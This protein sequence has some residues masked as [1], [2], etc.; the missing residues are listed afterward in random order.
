MKQLP[1]HTWCCSGYEFP[2]TL[3]CAHTCTH[4]EWQTFAMIIKI[5]MKWNELYSWGYNSVIKK[6]AMQAGRPVAG[7]PASTEKMDLVAHVCNLGFRKAETGRSLASTD[8]WCH[9]ISRLGSMRELMLKSK[10]KSSQKHAWCQPVASTSRCTHVPANMYVHTWTKN[11]YRD[12][13]HIPMHN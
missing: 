8:H 2:L 5:P 6:L 13:A 11:T 9:Q 10:M 1:F 3:R 7:S 4:K 12:T